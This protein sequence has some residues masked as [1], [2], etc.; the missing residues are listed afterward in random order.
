MLEPQGWDKLPAGE[1]GHE[2]LLGVHSKFL[3]RHLPEFQ[4]TWVFLPWHNRICLFFKTLSALD[5]LLLLKLLQNPLKFCLFDPFP[6][7][8]CFFLLVVLEFEL[9]HLPLEPFHQPFF[10]RGKE[11]AEYCRDR[12]S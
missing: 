6:T 4:P 7:W 11:G 12:V 5:I 1:N 3:R 8:G 10:W 9:Q 2:G